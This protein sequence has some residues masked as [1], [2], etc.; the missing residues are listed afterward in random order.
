[1]NEFVFKRS[2]NLGSGAAENDGE[3]LKECFVETPEYKTLLDYSDHRMILLG[4]TGSGK[5]A[6][7]KF[8]EPH[9]DVYIPIRPDTF[10]LQY[11]SNMPFISNLEG[12]GINLEVFYKFLWLHEI[13]S[14]IIKGYFTYNRKS[15]VSLFSSH[16][17]DGGR[18][19]QMKRYFNEYGEVFFESNSAANITDLMEQSVSAKMGVPNLGYLEGNL[20]ETQKREIQTAAS[21]YINT[22]QI[23]QLKN[24]ISLLKVYLSNNKQRKIFVAIDD[25]DQHW[26]GDETKYKLLSALLD[27]IRYFVDVPCLKI[28]LA[29]RSDLLSRTCEETNRQ[30]EK[31]MS[32]TLKISWTKQMLW[33]V[34]NRRIQ[35]LFSHKYQKSYRVSCED[36]FQPQVSGES[37]SDYLINRTMMRP[38]DLITFVNFCIEH[39]DEKSVIDADSIHE[40]EKEYLHDRIHAIKSEWNSVYPNI[41]ALLT[42][43]YKMPNMFDVSDVVRSYD[44]CEE[45]LLNAQ[46]TDGGLVQAFL[47]TP[48]NSEEFKRR[49]VQSLINIWFVLGV[50]GKRENKN[51][52]YSSPSRDMLDDRDFHDA[53]W[54]EIHPL[55]RQ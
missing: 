48:K 27:S 46:N 29:M 40:A 52:I 9:V 19:E 5:T 30:N 10:A 36:V 50:V 14:K 44:V 35:Y 3:F 25:L 13:M 11:I 34:L 15:F 51:V 16:I 22:K 2:L 24:I 6:L 54:F 32:F 31:D 53:D 23:S 55:F 45:V 33:G 28:I 20:T 41:D 26:I 7:L 18:I 39:S 12:Y 42:L 17:T 4:R 21:E 47:K 43:L 49:N 8:I 38:R 1:M 37:V